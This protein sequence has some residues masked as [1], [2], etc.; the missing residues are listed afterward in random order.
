MEE[1]KLDIKEIGLD[2]AED[3][4]KMAIKRVVRPYAEQYI[5]ESENKIDDIILPFVGQLEA[6]LLEM[7]DK[8]DGEK[9]I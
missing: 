7:V 4:L 2:L 6:A 8:I 9:D 5:Q 1:K 3:V